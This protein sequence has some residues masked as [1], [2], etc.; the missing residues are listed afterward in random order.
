MRWWRGSRS[1]VVY[2]RFAIVAL[3]CHGILH[4]LWTSKFIN[5]GFVITTQRAFL[6][7]FQ[8]DRHDPVPDRKTIH[9]L[10]NTPPGA[11]LISFEE[12]HFNLS[13][14]VNKQDYRY[15]A[16]ENPRLLYQRPLHNP[17]LTVWCAVTEFGVWSPYFFEEDKLTVTVTSDRHCNMIETFLRLKLNQFLGDH[18]EQK[19]CFQQDGAT[20]HMGSVSRTD[21]YYGL[22]L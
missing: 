18:E 4:L 8:L 13:G 15:W 1:L 16:A 3:A 11:V 22:S 14:T 19:V 7:R 6:M 20:A 12:A 9:T 10:H 5:G 21:I 17:R 2:V